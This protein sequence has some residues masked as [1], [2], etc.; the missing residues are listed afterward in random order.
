M[1]RHSA[2]R[3]IG[4]SP[5]RYGS[6]S[7]GTRWLGAAGCGKAGKVR[8]GAERMVRSGAPRSG[9]A[10]MAIQ[11]GVGRGASSSGVVYSGMA[12]MVRRC[13][14]GRDPVQRGRQFT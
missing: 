12:G 8:N 13:L 6:E 11:G 10:G 5:G 7:Q 1:L 2:T 3:L 9:P 4:V 14:V